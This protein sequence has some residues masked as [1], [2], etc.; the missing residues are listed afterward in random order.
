[1]SIL[2]RILII[3]FLLFPISKIFVQNAYANFIGPGGS[4]DTSNYAIRVFDVNA[5][6]TDPRDITFNNDGTKMFTVDTTADDVFEYTLSLSSP[7]FRAP[8]PTNIFIPSL[9]KSK[10]KAV[11]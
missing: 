10:P 1:M 11:F 9:V 6:L 7:A 8:L 5:Q 3:F 4:L 2:K